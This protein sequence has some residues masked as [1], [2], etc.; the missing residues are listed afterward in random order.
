MT[1]RIAAA[2]ARGKRAYY[3][4]SK[5]LLREREMFSPYE[6]FPQSSSSS[7]PVKA[8]DA[9]M[10]WGN[11]FLL[12]ARITTSAIAISML[13]I[14]V[15]SM[16]GYLLLTQPELR[17]NDDMMAFLFAVA[18]NVFLSFG[19]IA[20]S[21]FGY[22]ALFQRKAKIEFT[23]DALALKAWGFLGAPVRKSFDFRE[24]FSVEVVEIGRTRI[25]IVTVATLRQGEQSIVL[26]SDEPLD[27]QPIQ[28][29]A[30]I[31]SAR[32]RSA[33]SQGIWIPKTTLENILALER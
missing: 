22:P 30:S 19:L 26:C 6:S 25:G 24:P 2:S 13:V 21:V 32:A 3:P 12:V 27:A 14:S 23:N 20:M 18:V 10:S 4:A 31:F 33:W 8:I 15:T 16:I 9:T 17:T 5:S 29:R 28:A 7:E 1:R 11:K